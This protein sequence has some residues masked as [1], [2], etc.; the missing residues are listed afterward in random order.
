MSMRLYAVFVKTSGM[1]HGKI[2]SSDLI[3]KCENNASIK[4]THA[5]IILWIVF[6]PVC[7]LCVMTPLCKLCL[8]TVM[9]NK[10]SFA[11]LLNCTAHTFWVYYRMWIS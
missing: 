4:A 6:L 11:L 9:T 1:L 7:S 3:C 8:H 2:P 10:S 5:T